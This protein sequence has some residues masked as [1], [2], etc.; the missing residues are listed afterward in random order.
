MLFL[1]SQDAW[2]VLENPQKGHS[3]E[4]DG[5]CLDC[6]ACWVM[7]GPCWGLGET[8]LCFNL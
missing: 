4:F 7:A 1:C 5:H 3:R 2:Q 6:L 8:W